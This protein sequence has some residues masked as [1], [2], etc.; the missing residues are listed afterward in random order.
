VQ[1]ILREDDSRNVKVQFILREDDSHSL[2]VQVASLMCSLHRR[3]VV[4]SE[5]SSQNVTLPKNAT[6]NP[7]VGKEAASCVCARA[8]KQK[9][10]AERGPSYDK[11]GSHVVGRCLGKA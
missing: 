1:F 6:V 7:A 5:D 9:L 3:G 11:G 4:L 8:S 2:K 10:K